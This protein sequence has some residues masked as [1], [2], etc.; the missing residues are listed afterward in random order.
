MI[1]FFNMVT[2]NYMTDRGQLTVP[3]CDGW[4][5]ATLG[6]N[7]FPPCYMYTCSRFIAH[8][9]IGRMEALWPK[10]FGVQTESRLMRGSNLHHRLFKAGSKDSHERAGYTVV[11]SKMRTRLVLLDFLNF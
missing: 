11:G 5:L 4:R 10:A 7:H 8:A 3:A 9:L 6:R 2:A 1:K